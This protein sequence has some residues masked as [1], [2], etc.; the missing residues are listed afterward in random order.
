M[1]EQ[2]LFDVASTFERIVDIHRSPEI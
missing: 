1:E 2:T